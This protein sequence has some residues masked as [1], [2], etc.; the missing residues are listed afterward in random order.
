MQ[1]RNLIP[2]L[3]ISSVLIFGLAG[4]GCSLKGLDGP[5]APQPEGASI[6][7]Q[8]ATT[9]DEWQFD[10]SPYVQEQYGS[11]PTW[12]VI[13]GGG[14]IDGTQYVR[15]FNTTGSYPVRVRAEYTS[16]QT[17]DSTFDVLVQSG[18]LAVVQSGNDLFIYDG[19]AGG[20]TEM[21]SG[22]SSP[23]NYRAQ[24]PNGWFVYE[25]LGGSSTDLFV[26]DMVS[27]F[28]VGPSLSLDTAYAGHSASSVLLYEQ[29]SAFETG[30]Y[31]WH[32]N[33]PWS[34][35]VAWRAGMHNRNPVVSDSEVVYFEYGN[36]GQPDLYFWNYG[37]QNPTTAFSSDYPEEIKTAVPGGGVVFSTNNPF[38]LEDD[39]FYY[40]MHNG[41]YTV[42]GDL[43][44]SVQALDMTYQGQL[45]GGMVVFST[46]AFLGNQDLYLWSPFGL[47]TAS[48]ATGPSVER[49]VGITP[50]DRVLYSVGTAP[51]N[52][53]LRLYHHTTQATSVVASSSDNELFEA[54]LPN[55]DVIFAVESASGRQ[56]K[57]F[58]VISSSVDVIADA[59][60]E[61][62]ELADVLSNGTVVYTQT[63]SSP[64]LHVWDPVEGASTFVAGAGSAFMGDAGNGNFV[65]SQDSGVQTDLVMWDSSTSQL[66]AITQT[67]E[68]EQFECVFTN[69]TV[70]FS[71]VVAPSVTSDLFKWN[72][73][74]GEE[75]RLTTGTVNHSVVTVIHGAP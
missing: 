36:N 43:E 62:F 24:L 74:D 71:R 44:A 34:E 61:D 6:P 63:G 22:G 26:Y 41:S 60:G 45:S 48:I 25:R 33:G 28:E 42:G 29:G 47:N 57:R 31:A 51:G 2:T 14:T 70:L 7:S 46:T 5:D 53:D 37:D 54:F 69:G 35:N 1:V 16:G 64:G 30:L 39:L 65:L 55:S 17:A 68:E 49:F 13:S 56:L 11:E 59:P 12:T 19:D 27:S 58:N 15:T 8:V 75:V 72:D 20:L 50:D 38:T 10:L 21:A 3:A 73:A 32:P 18:V 66:V 23:L 40:R 4:S 52:E 67:D 9:Y